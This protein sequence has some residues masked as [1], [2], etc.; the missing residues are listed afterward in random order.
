M[1]AVKYHK[2]IVLDNDETNE[3]LGVAGREARIA[4]PWYGGTLDPDS[5]VVRPV[6]PGYT[7]PGKH[8]ARGRMTV[9]GYGTTPITVKILRFPDTGE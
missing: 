1:G 2:Q 8:H 3:A 5:V 7:G 6:V 9:S 4:Q